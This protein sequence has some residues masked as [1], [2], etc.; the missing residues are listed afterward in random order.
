MHYCLYFIMI[1]LGLFIV[2]ILLLLR[3]IYYC[4]MKISMVDGPV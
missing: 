4:T 1:P 3:G 2:A